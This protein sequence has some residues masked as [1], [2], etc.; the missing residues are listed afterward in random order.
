MIEC[1]RLNVS[2]CAAL[3]SLFMHLKM[4]GVDGGPAT[5][6]CRGEEVRQVVASDTVQIRWG[7]RLAC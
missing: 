6:L 4:C 7:A 1:V 2:H 3:V 5:V